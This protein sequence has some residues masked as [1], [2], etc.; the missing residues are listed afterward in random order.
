MLKV[1]QGRD[2]LEEPLTNSLTV[3]AIAVQLLD[4]DAVADLCVESEVCVGGAPAAEQTLDSITVAQEFASTAGWPRAETGQVN[5]GETFV[6][7]EWQPL[8]ALCAV[9]CSPSLAQIAP[10]YPLPS[11][12]TVA[13]GTGAFGRSMGALPAS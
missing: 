5:R 4:N 13:L 9:A 7:D 12:R 6:G 3:G 2:F 1:R 11:L 10:G 8:N